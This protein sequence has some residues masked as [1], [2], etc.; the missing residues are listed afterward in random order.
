[1][2]GCP[3]LRDLCEGWDV[4][5]YPSRLC[6]VLPA[7]SD[8]EIRFEDLDL[9]SVILVWPGVTRNVEGYLILEEFTLLLAP[10]VGTITGGTSSGKTCFG[11]TVTTRKDVMF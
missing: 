9:N 8:G 1:M 11:L 4:N 7:R 10:R 3:I 5:R 6:E 2:L